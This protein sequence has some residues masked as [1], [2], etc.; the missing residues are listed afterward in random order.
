MARVACRTDREVSCTIA[1]L[2]A[3]LEQP[4]GQC[5]GDGVV[6]MGTSPTGK[7]I[8]V[9]LLGDRVLEVTG[10]DE[11]LEEIRGRRCPP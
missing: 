9:R 10:G 5:D 6:L 2:L 4:C 7:P 8:T 11:L 1:N 3:E